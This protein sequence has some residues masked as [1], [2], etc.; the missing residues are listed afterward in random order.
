[1]ELSYKSINTSRFWFLEEPVILAIQ[2]ALNLLPCTLRRRRHSRN[3]ELERYVA[4]HEKIPMSLVA[5]KD[6]PIS[7]YSVC[8]SN[9]ISVLT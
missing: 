3:L 6:K 8:F 7:P 5:G 2:M 9:T 1:M 4:Q